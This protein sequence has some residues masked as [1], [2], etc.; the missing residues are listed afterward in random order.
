MNILELQARNPTVNYSLSSSWAATS[1]FGSYFS[2]VLGNITQFGLPL[3]ENLLCHYSNSFQL[4]KIYTPVVRVL[5]FFQP[6]SRFHPKLG[7]LLVPSVVRLSDPSILSYKK[8]ILGF[9]RKNLAVEYWKMWPVCRHGNLIWNGDCVG[10]DGQLW[11]PQEVWAKVSHRAARG[12]G[13]WPH[14]SLLILQKSMFWDV[15]FHVL[16][17]YFLHVR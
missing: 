13:T 17:I 9:I 2:P 16:Y 11:R 5:G 7:P 1:F 4:S 3:Y 14:F 8:L 6:R 15:L 10:G 12:E